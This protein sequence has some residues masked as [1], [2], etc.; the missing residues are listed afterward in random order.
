MKRKK[1]YIGL[2]LDEKE[3]GFIDSLADSL[4][5]TRSEVISYLIRAF[6]VLTV[7]PLINK[8]KKEEKNLTPPERKLNYII[9]KYRLPF[10]FVGDGEVKVGGKK[11][12]FI[13]EIGN[14]VYRII[15]VFGRHYHPLTDEEER[16]RFFSKYGIPCLVFWKDELDY[17]P[18][19]RIADIIIDF[20]EDKNG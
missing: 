6:R 13:M 7:V 20:V 18:E 12:D 16:K 5:I 10:R 19:E 3:M 17:L 4:E 8:I 1:E 9:K 11:P 14:Y 2:R 15:E